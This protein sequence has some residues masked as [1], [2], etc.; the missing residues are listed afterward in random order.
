MSPRDIAT[1]VVGYVSHMEDADGTIA[2]WKAS[3]TITL[4]E[5]PVCD[6][7]AFIN[8]TENVISVRPLPCTS[9]KSRDLEPA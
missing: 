1:D 3:S 9:A 2:S 5:Y 6:Y 4:V 7:R 8:S